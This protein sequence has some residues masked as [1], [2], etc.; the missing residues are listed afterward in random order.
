MS[1]ISTVTTDKVRLSFVHLLKPYAY[2]PGQEEKYSCTILLPKSDVATKQRLDAAVQAAIERG[3]SDKWSGVR[4]PQIPV[5]IY[6]GD[7]VKPSDGM[8]FGDECKGH[9]VFTA[10]AKVDYKPEVVDANLN[11]IINPTEVYSGMYARVNISF[12]PYSFAGK[13][14]IGCGL[15]P[16]QK[17]ADGEPLGGSA[18]RASD[19]FSA[20]Q[21]TQKV[22]PITGQPLPF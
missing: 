7:G 8:P 12:Y 13:K 10:S 15:G 6:D 2:Q 9:W 11:P 18:P 1:N 17:I 4:P 5:P 3:V 14:G 21:S 22:N 16:I 20:V 19:V